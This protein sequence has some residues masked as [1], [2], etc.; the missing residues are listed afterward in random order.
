MH[1][2]TKLQL[3][4]I[5][6]FSAAMR[7]AAITAAQRKAMKRKPAK[8]APWP[9]IMSLFH[10]HGGST[11]P[12]TSASNTSPLTM[13]QHS[14]A[15]SDTASSSAAPSSPAAPHQQ[16]QGPGQPA[17]AE[18]H[19][20]RHPHSLSN[21]FGDNHSNHASGHSSGLLD[22]V[23]SFFRTLSCHKMHMHAHPAAPMA[24]RV[25]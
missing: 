14:N 15:S 8:T 2:G 16:Q 12:S 18:P 21:I 1:A 23:K 13:S 7:C 4:G 6:A 17:H 25:A 11:S 20:H 19:G 10:R 3:N 22:N 5:N 24:T 9:A